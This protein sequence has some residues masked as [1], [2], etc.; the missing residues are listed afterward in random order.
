MYKWRYGYRL[1]LQTGNWEG[2][3]DAASAS[4]VQLTHDY[5]VHTN[6]IELGPNTASHNNV[7]TRTIRYDTTEEFNLDSKAEYTA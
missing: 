4:D 3:L 6:K 1:S 2:A 7:L 5:T